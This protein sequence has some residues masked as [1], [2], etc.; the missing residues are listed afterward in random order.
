MMNYIVETCIGNY[1]LSNLIQELK[2]D[3]LS[4]LKENVKELKLYGSY[5]R[6]DYSSDSD[7]DICLLYDGISV[8]NIDD[9]SISYLNKYISIS[10]LIK[11]IEKEG[12]VI[13]QVERD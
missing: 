4:L 6:G 3:I 9:L 12:I 8:E 11:N 7:I 10:P 13:Y 1:K 5:A 2:N